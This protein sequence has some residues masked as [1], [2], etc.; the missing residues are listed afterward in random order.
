M[1]S[2]LNVDTIVD[3]A[4]SGGSNIKIASTSVTVSEGGSVTTTTVQGLTKV[5]VNYDGTVSNAASRDSFNVS[6]QTDNGTGDYTTTYSNNMNNDDYACT[7][8]ANGPECEI[9]GIETSFLRKLSNSSGGSSIDKSVQTL[10]I[11]GDLA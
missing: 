2:Q 10:A 3:K 6:G 11:H 9:S 8:G 4:G 1:T 7:F 5:W